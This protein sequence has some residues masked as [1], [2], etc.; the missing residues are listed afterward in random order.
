MT[1]NYKTGPEIG[2]TLSYSTKAPSIV[3]TLG[4]KKEIFLDKFL[5]PND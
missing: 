5:T 1:V 2:Q 4:T 3:T